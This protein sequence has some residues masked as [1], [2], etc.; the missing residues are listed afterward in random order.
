MVCL[1]FPGQ[2]QT[3]KMG[4]TMN[5]RLTMGKLQSFSFLVSIKAGHGRAGQ[6]R[7]TS[8]ETQAITFS[9]NATQLTT[10]WGTNYDDSFEQWI[11]GYWHKD[12]QFSSQRHSHPTRNNHNSPQECWGAWMNDAWSVNCLNK[13]NTAPLWGQLEIHGQLESWLWMN[14]NH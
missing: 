10:F 11:W 2:F 7:P 1:A 13:W 4:L 8:G 9:S 12:D 3:S 5:N 14:S 6:G